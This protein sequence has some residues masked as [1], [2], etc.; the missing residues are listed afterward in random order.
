[1]L[2]FY[3]EQECQREANKLKT[4]CDVWKI[5]LY[6]VSEVIFGIL[7]YNAWQ[8]HVDHVL[9]AGGFEQMYKQEVGLFFF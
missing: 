4:D 3:K 5:S 7:C 2:A 8:M 1:M 6:I 9:A